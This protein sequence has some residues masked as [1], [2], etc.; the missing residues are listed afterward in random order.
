[1]A[2]QLI[3][4]GLSS[5]EASLTEVKELFERELAGSAD[6]L[7]PLIRH[8]SHF[9]GKMLRPRLVL[10]AGLAAVGGPSIR[11]S[12]CHDHT[13][14]AAVV[15]MVH[16]ATLVH[17]DV[18]DGADVRRRAATINH[19]KGNQAA[20]LLGDM[21]ISHAFHLCSGLECQAYSRLIGKTTNLVCEGELLQNLSE[22]NWHLTADAYFDIIYR[23]TASLI[24]TSC[25]L[26]AMAANADRD[27]IEA[28]AQYGRHIGIAFQI[29]DDILD[30]SGSTR[31]VG[32]S[33]GTDIEQGKLTLPMIHFLNAADQP[34]RDLLIG[35]L[36]SSDPDRIDHVR[37]L[38]QPTGS[39][40]YAKN[41]ARAFVD[42]A[43]AAVD[44]LPHS[45]FKLNLIEMARYVTER[46][47]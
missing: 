16:V 32:K 36:E 23:K 26:G 28:L 30:I 3:A 5:L 35:L 33:L 18:L 31:L 34:H 29:V 2:P 15:E 8:I 44:S 38:L 27:A 42:R 14:L 7:M 6:A 39:M 22:R 20:V 47:K 9:R 10:L 25:R 43:V 41:E 46:E 40:A 17:D 1:M 24:E 19:L 12:L 4:D 13:V 45:E 11:P 21:L 37:K